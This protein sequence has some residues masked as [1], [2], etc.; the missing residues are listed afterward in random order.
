VGEAKK[1]V[2]AYKYYDKTFTSIDREE[3]KKLYREH[4]KHVHMD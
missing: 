3:I 4:L 2:S 1:H